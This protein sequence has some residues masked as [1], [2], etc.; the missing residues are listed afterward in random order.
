[1]DDLIYKRF[2]KLLQDKYKSKPKLRSFLRKEYYT[3]DHRVHS[4]NS[5]LLRTTDIPLGLPFHMSAKSEEFWKS[6][7]YLDSDSRNTGPEQYNKALTIKTKDQ[8]R[9]ALSP[10]ELK[11]SLFNNQKKI[12]PICSEPLDITL[13]NNGKFVEIDHNPRVHDLKKNIWEKLSSKYGFY[14]EKIKITRELLLSD[15]FNSDFDKFY[16]QESK[17]ISVRLVH[18]DCNRKDAIEANKESAQQRKQIKAKL[19][20]P[21][22]DYLKLFLKKTGTLIRARTRFLWD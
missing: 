4:E 12:C 19:N 6:N 15:S 3:E 9:R 2:W 17:N 5:I 7:I 18:K 22:L 20:K 21:A 1:L 8:K 11:T 10:L 13:I 14:D 16:H